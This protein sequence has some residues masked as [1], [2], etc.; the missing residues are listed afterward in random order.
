MSLHTAGRGC[1]SPFWPKLQVDPRRGMALFQTK[2]VE[3]SQDLIQHHAQALQAH[4]SA[5]DKARGYAWFKWDG[6][7][8]KRQ[9][10]RPYTSPDLSSKEG[11][12]GKSIDVVPLPRE[13]TEAAM[14]KACLEKFLQSAEEIDGQPLG[15]TE[16]EMHWIR[17]RC[18]GPP[19]E[20]SRV[21][22]QDGFKFVGL[23]ALERDNVRGAKNF[24]A[25]EKNGTPFFDEFLQ[26]GD[27]LIFNDAELWHWV[28][29]LEVTDSSRPGYRSMLILSV[30]RRHLAGQAARSCRPFNLQARC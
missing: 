20:V 4:P 16:V 21:P 25:T 24:L 30:G 29:D 8:L 14:T 13:F 5:P 6:G 7:E 3:V 9:A 27:C 2:V 15:D 18:Q 26:V 23:F 11:R 17:T 22:H 12:P 19:A 28:T 10:H 1:R